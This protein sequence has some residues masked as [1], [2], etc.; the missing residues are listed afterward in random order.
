[1]TEV[2]DSSWNYEEIIGRFTRSEEVLRGVI[3]KGELL[4]AARKGLHE[5]ELSIAK[6]DHQIADA[7]SALIS[8]A[9]EMKNIARDT[10]I[11]VQ[12]LKPELVIKYLDDLKQDS[13]KSRGVQTRFTEKTDKSLGVI[14][15]QV[16]EVANRVDSVI[17][18]LKFSHRL[19]W[20][21]VAL[22]VAAGV[23]S[24]VH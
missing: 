18:S 14:I 17:T 11:S 8:V 6:L 24:W 5:A 9:T 22:T 1:M 20:A 10:M 23:A 16:G 7:S 3:D 13:E 4:V 21:V 2:T 12:K 15:D 19:M